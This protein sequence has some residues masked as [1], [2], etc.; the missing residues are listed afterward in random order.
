MSAYWP[1]LENLPTFDVT[2]FRDAQDVVDYAVASGTATNISGGTAGALLYQSAPSV[3]AKLGIGANTYVLTSNGTGPVWTAPTSSSISTTQTTTQP[4]YLLGSLNQTTSNDATLY[5]SS[6]LNGVYVNPTTNTLF[7]GELVILNSNSNPFYISFFTPSSD[8]AIIFNN[9]F[10]GGIA[11]NTFFYNLDSGGNQR[12]V[13]TLNGDSGASTF[14]GLS[15]KS[16]TVAVAD[17]NSAT[18]MYPIFTTATAG[19]KSLLFDSTTTPLRYKPS[20]G[21]IS[22]IQCSVGGILEPVAGN[23]AGFLAQNTGSSA[24]VVQNQA[25]SGLIHLAV[26]NGANV[27]TNSV[28]VSATDA[29]ASQFSVGSISNPVS[30]NNAG[31]IAQNTGANATVIQNQA[32]S[33][34]IYLNTRDAGSL[35]STVA[36]VSTVSSIVRSPLSVVAGVVGSAATFTVSD[37]GTRSVVFI[38]NASAGA[39]NSLVVLNDSLLYATA[40]TVGTGA[41]TLSVWSATTNGVRITPTSAVIGAGGTSSIPTAAISCSG[42]TVSIIGDP[43]VED[44]NILVNNQTGNPITVGNGASTAS[45][46]ILMSSGSLASTKNFTTGGNT[47]IGQMAGNA[48]VVASA[49]N[50]IIGDNAGTLASGSRNTIIGFGAQAPT[51]ANSNQIAIGTSSETLY[52]QGGFNLRVG[53][54]I[55]ASITLTAPLAQF[56]TVA[57]AAATQTITLPAPNNTTLLGQTVTFK[58]KTNTTA[59]TLAAGAGTPLISIGSITAVATIAVATTTFQVTLVCDGVNWDVINQT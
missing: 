7:S 27:L 49:N 32:T 26:R 34:K 12:T 1:P 13:L 55:T 19:Q 39:L 14:D 22:A 57:M 45:Y 28:V 54:Q 15:A 43:V 2:V 24:T 44:N 48:L 16:T 36:E 50:T 52:V 31:L 33:G 17:N 47:L 4:Y 59:F 40:G 8:D 5:K 23:N 42:T 37:T 25:T 21:E 51:A 38:P 3:T 20:T 11:N 6:V 35:L 53:T 41:L 46:N 18:T 29:A 9:S 56:Y 30:G 58:R 10:N